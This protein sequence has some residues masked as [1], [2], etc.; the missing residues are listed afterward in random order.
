MRGIST[1]QTL[2]YKD[3]LR[4]LTDP[5]TFGQTDI[6][7]TQFSPMNRAVDPHQDRKCIRKQDR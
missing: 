3:A 6:S 1:G 4:G 2:E 7:K 5:G